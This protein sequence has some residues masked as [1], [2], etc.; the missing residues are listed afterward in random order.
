MYTELVHT[1]LEGYLNNVIYYL[2]QPSSVKS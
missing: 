2:L 1:D